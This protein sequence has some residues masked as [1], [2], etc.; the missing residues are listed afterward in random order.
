VQQVHK[1]FKALQALKVQLE[2]RAPQA[3]RVHRDRKVLVALL[4]GQ[5]HR[6]YKAHKV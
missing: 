2:L 4:F 1:A 6:V 3:H 5:V